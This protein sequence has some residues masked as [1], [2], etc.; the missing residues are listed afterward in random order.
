MPYIEQKRELWI[1]ELFRLHLESESHFSCEFHGLSLQLLRE[2]FCPAYG[3]SSNILAQSLCQVIQDG[4]SV[5]DLGTGS[6]ALA[7]LAANQGASVVVATDIS[8]ISV[9]CTQKNIEKHNLIERIDT[10]LGDLF[11]TIQPDERFSIIV[12]NPPFMNRIAST[13]LEKTMY[14]FQYLTL[15]KFFKNFK[16]HLI[17]TGK[18]LVVFSELGDI[19]F[20][21]RLVEESKCQFRIV[22]EDIGLRSNLRTVVYELTGAVTEYLKG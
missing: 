11:E 15:I 2:V 5:L 1:N 18:V 9:A 16:L 4:D 14:D 7:I 13:W 17:P 12:F 6:G 20:F 10:R 3:E 8:P 21:T 19:I 22:K